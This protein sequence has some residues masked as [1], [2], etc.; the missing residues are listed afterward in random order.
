MILIVLNGL[1]SS[2]ESFVTSQTVR[3]NDISF[4]AFRSLLQAHEEKL[5]Q[6]S[7]EFAYHASANFVRS[8]QS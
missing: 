2:Y 8:N 7:S 5:K 6:K 1:D 3:A 4:V